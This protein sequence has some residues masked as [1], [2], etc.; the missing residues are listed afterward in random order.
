[1]TPIQ[2]QSIAIDERDSRCAG[3]TLIELLVVSATVS[4]L[5]ALLL[6]AVQ[7]VREAAARSAAS[8]KLQLYCA[9]G[10]H[11]Y[12]QT[13]R[14]PTSLAEL[15]PDAAGPVQEADGYS[16]RIVPG[17]GLRIEA[18]PTH[19]GVTGSETLVAKVGPS[20]EVEIESVPTPGAEEGRD[21]MWRNIR[22]GGVR[23]LESTLAESPEAVPSVHSAL[24]DPDVL[25]EA[26][27]HLDGDGDGRF[28]LVD[29]SA[30]LSENVPRPV[31]ELLALAGREMRLDTLSPE[32]LRSVEVDLGE[33]RGEP[34]DEPFDWGTLG[35][36]TA[37]F[38]K[39]PDASKS[40][41]VKLSAAEAAWRRGDR[42]T[43]V[44]RLDEY[45][46]L[47][48][49]QIGSSLTRRDGEALRMLAEV[50]KT[51]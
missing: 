39:D 4:V 19:P 31:A 1:M 2:R 23:I 12:E 14:Y 3:F 11:F 44:R 16:F 26:Y 29:S 30:T 43:Q 25:E 5:M 9:D 28:E 8:A 15:G 32:L 48:D 49:A 27:R 50:A 42:R 20:G 7:K 46:A 34:V 41:R 51:L 17:D 33:L 35:E 6:P 47:V 21:E 24:S 36:M 38:V 45:I 40:M 37:H 13:G 10:K 18:E 22:A